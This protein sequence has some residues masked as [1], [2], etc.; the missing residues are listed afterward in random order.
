MHGSP[1]NV[2]DWSLQRRAALRA[3]LA[4]RCHRSTRARSSLACDHRRE[5]LRVNGEHSP[6]LGPERLERILVERRD[7]HDVRHGLDANR[8]DHAEAV[9]LRHR[10]SR[11]TSLAKLGDA[12]TASTPVSASPT[13]SIS[14]CSAKYRR[15][16]A[17]AGASSSTIR[18]RTRARPNE[19][20]ERRPR[21]RQRR[22]RWPTPVTPRRPSP[23]VVTAA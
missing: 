6:A 2:A 10:T 19:R 20:P 17:R 12:L 9:E 7:E 16:F 8:V 3:V 21:R 14:G 1:S 15:I 13:I 23:R 5:S 11:N 4:P 18:T 22:P